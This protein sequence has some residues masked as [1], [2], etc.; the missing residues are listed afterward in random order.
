MRKAVEKAIAIMN[1]DP[2]LKS[3]GVVNIQIIETGRSRGSQLAYYAQGYHEYED[4]KDKTKTIRTPI[5]DLE[6]VNHLRKRVGLAPISKKTN[7]G[8]SPTDTL[9]SYHIKGL[10]I[11]LAP[12]HYNEEGKFETWWKAPKEVWERM[13]KIGEENGLDWCH[14]LEGKDWM[15]PKDGSKPFSDPPHFELQDPKI[16]RK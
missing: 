9:R 3:K 8:R 15:H 2:F 1:K 10:A 5:N 4:P 14:D 6:L 16:W 12:N 13:G 11:D 7:E